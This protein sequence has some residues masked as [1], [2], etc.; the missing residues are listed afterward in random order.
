[1]QDDNDKKHR[2][3]D[4]RRVAWDANYREKNRQKRRQYDRERMRARRRDGLS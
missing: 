4:P 3:P 1:M 2:E